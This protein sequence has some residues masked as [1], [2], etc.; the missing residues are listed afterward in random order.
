VG[1]VLPKVESSRSGDDGMTPVG[2]PRAPPSYANRLTRAERGEEPLTAVGAVALIGSGG[3]TSSVGFG[4]RWG[5]ARATPH[6]LRE[7]PSTRRMAPLVRLPTRQRTQ[8]LASWG[9]PAYRAGLGP[10][11]QQDNPRQP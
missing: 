9:G 6:H 8:S 10:Q 7:A 3:E 11:R 4:R 1:A 5:P 2:S